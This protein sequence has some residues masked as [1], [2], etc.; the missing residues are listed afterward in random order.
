MR[1]SFA[2]ICLGLAVSGCSA[3]NPRNAGNGPNMPTMVTP[4]MLEPPPIYSILGFRDKIQLTS[5]QITSLDSIATWVHDE[6]VPLIQELREGATPTRN[7]VGM[8]IPDS[9]RPKLDAV[10]TNNRTAASGVGKVL[11]TTQQQS[12]CQI[13]E[14]QAQE[15]DSDRGRGNGSPRPR[16]SRLGSEADSILASARRSVWPF[17]RG[18][19]AVKQ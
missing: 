14:E 3:S 7:Q 16:T 2:L 10:R 6:N 13:F 15:R 17:C 4:L 9:L 18:N 11:T 8:V 19:N 5:A 12:A 1:R